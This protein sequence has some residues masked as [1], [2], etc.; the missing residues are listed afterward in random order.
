MLLDVGQKIENIAAAGRLPKD[1]IELLQANHLKELSELEKK[2][3]K[4][5]KKDTK[6]Q[7]A[8]IRQTVAKHAL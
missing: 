7:D 4:F 1:E 2:L 6:A 5:L 8:I 3:E